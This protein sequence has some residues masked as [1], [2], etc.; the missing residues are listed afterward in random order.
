MQKDWVKFQSVILLV[1][2]L[3]ILGACALGAHKKGSPSPKLRAE[4]RAL[5]WEKVDRAE[6]L[7]LKFRPGVGRVETTEYFSQSLLEGFEEGQIVVKR[8]ETALF[9]VKAEGQADSTPEQIRW[10][11]TTVKK[12]GKLDLHDLAFP[13]PGEKLEMIYDSKAQV[14]KA[15]AFPKSSI[16]YVPPL[17]LPE[18]AV[19]VGD[20]WE[21]T[22]QWINLKNGLP[23][24]M[25]LVTV[26]KDL[27]K[28]GL[29]GLCA[30]LEVSAAVDIMNLDKNQADFQSDIHGRL[31][32]SIDKGT[33]IWSLVRNRERYADARSSMRVSSCVVSYLIE[34][35]KE[36]LPKAKVQ[37]DAN[38]ESLDL[39]INL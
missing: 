37:C 26:F 30:D 2:C 34:P 17:S 32:F 12:D 27:Y 29:A 10:I 38:L 4:M 39:P 33:V 8:D 7:E 18:K 35:S 13:E 28:C 31:L 5:G 36:S 19:K 24:V 16:F 15:G 21:M 1:S 9:T 20:T 11:F 14:L 22:A 25:S 23:M 3:A 6:P